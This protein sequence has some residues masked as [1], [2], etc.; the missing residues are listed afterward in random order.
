MLFIECACAF[1]EIA[2]FVTDLAHLD[3]KFF[4]RFV[5]RTFRADLF[6]ETIPISLQSLQPGLDLAP[7]RIDPEHVGDLRVIA[8]AA[9][10]KPLADKIWFLTNQAD[11]EHGADYRLS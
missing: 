7:F 1:C 2:Y 8:T 5:A 10:R 3:F 6:A 9:R 4:A 11:V